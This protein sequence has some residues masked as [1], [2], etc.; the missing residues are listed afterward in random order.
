LSFISQLA[1]VRITFHHK[2]EEAEDISGIFQSREGKLIHKFLDELEKAADI[3]K[4]LGIPSFA[5]FFLVSTDRRFRQQGLAKELY[6]RSIKF[7]KA[8]GFKHAM[9]VTTSPHTKRSTE[10]LGFDIIT[11]KEY[12]EF[13]DFEG[14]PVFSK[15]ELTPDHFALLK[16]I[17]LS[18]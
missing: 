13:K 6:E 18:K 16:I 15:E 7:L 2:G 12:S 8:E 17:D 1:A 5:E 14:N 3:H 11:R 9:V 10:K 4:G